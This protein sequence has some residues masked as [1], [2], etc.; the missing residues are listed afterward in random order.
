VA[1]NETNL[2]QALI[3]FATSL[4]AQHTMIASVLA[5]LVSLREAVRGLDPTFEEVIERTRKETFQ[6]IAE[7]T[8]SH[9]REY[10]SLI[11]LLKDGGI[12]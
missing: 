4:K 1:I 3:V 12:C 5:E 9:L 7:D 10:D 11:Q 6:K 8:Q 2:R